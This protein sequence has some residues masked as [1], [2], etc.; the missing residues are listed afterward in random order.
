[1]QI[2]GGAW[3]VEAMR[4]APLRPPARDDASQDPPSRPKPFAPLP[5]QARG[6]LIDLVV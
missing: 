5:A 2:A 1:M 4:S 3:I 6:L